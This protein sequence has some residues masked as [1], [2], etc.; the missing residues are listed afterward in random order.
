MNNEYKTLPHVKWMQGYELSFFFSDVDFKIEKEI[1]ILYSEFLCFEQNDIMQFK[2]II[3]FLF[4]GNLLFYENSDKITDLIFNC[5]ILSEENFDDIMSKP[6]LADFKTRL[7]TF[8]DDD[9]N[10]FKS[11]TSLLITLKLKL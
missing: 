6:I 1:N 3:V 11:V 5:T 2:G 9:V 8:L 4:K 10:N 7:E